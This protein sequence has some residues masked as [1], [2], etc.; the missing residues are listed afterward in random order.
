MKTLILCLFI[1]A[2]QQPKTI[3]PP[4]PSLL[5]TA[6]LTARTIFDYVELVDMGKLKKKD[7]GKFADP[8]QVKLD[9]I[10]KLLTPEEIK[11]LDDY[12]TKYVWSMAD[13]KVERD[14]KKKK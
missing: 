11:M 2:C 1:I 8:L 14:E 3:P 9:S 4:E 6:M 5:D 7:L 13:R 12:R 10:R